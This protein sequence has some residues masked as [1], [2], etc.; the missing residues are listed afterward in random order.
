MCLDEILCSRSLSWQMAAYSERKKTSYYTCDILWKLFQTLWE[1]TEWQY[2]E[3]QSIQFVPL[4]TWVGIWKNNI[5]L[6]MAHIV[7]HGGPNYK[8]LRREMCHF[9]QIS[10]SED[11]VAVLK[12]QYINHFLDLFPYPP[13]NFLKKLIIYLITLFPLSL[14]LHK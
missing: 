4:C 11:C 2:S 6:H 1:F 13:K 8:R 5:V 14:S 12:Y 7:C 10:L 3:V 9:K